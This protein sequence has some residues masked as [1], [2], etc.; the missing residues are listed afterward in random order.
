MPFVNNFE[1]RSI[2][3]SISL[4]LQ[5]D[6][7]HMAQN[8]TNHIV[9]IMLIHFFQHFIEICSFGGMGHKTINNK[10][11]VSF[12][13]VAASTTVGTPMAITVHPEFSQTIQFSCFL[14]LSLRYSRI[15]YL[16]CSIDTVH[17][18]RS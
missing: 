13:I 18:S 3:S 8:L 15:S 12:A 6:C 17:F 10:L 1:T 5:S 9:F 16:Y 11:T 7:P 2:T 14:L 4:V